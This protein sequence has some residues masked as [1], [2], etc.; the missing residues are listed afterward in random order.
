MKKLF[1][2][3]VLA[4][5]FLISCGK[6]DEVKTVVNSPVVEKQTVVTPPIVENPV[7]V[8]GSVVESSTGKVEDVPT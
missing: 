8:T 1:I 3:A 4:P 6:S 2:V 7:V 5:L